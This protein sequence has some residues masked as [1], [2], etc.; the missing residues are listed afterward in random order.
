MLTKTVAFDVENLD[1]EALVKHFG[2]L[3]KIASS[4][5]TSNGKKYL[6]GTVIALRRGKPSEGQCYDVQWEDTKMGMTPV[7]LQCI[8]PAISQSNKLRF[9][10]EGSNRN[11]NVKKIYAAS[12]ISE[13]FSHDLQNAIFA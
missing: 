4:L 10:K 12:T 13:L 1:G 2:G 6:V 8:I 11:D 3:Q 5:R 9:N 7:S